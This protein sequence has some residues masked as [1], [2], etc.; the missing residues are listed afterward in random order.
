MSVSGSFP[1][2]SCLEH[3]PITAYAIKTKTCWVTFLLSLHRLKTALPLSCIMP[4]AWGKKPICVYLNLDLCLS[5][6]R[7]MRLAYYFYRQLCS[8]S[9]YFCLNILD[10]GWCFG[11]AFTP[12]FHDVCKTVHDPSLSRKED[13]YSLICRSNPLLQGA[14]SARSSSAFVFKFNEETCS[15]A[16][17][18]SENNKGVT[19]MS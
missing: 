2:I 7:G 8:G 5:V 15:V 19:A 1:Q 17:S 10:K 4:Q 16:H 11:S 13:K 18:Q 14:S 12:W 6:E 9:V 3:S